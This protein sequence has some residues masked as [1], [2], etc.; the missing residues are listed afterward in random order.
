M[1]FLS[2]NY[3]KEGSNKAVLLFLFSTNLTGGLFGQP[4]IKLDKYRHP[5]V[6]DSLAQVYSKLI[7]IEDL[8]RNLSVLA[9]DAYE[10]RETG[11][12]G[13]KMAAA[14]IAQEFKKSGIP[15]Y[16]DTSY[17][18][19]FLLNVILPKPAEVYV[20]LKRFKNKK[21]FYTY[22]EQAEQH[23]ETGNIEFL[24]YGIEDKN[25]TDFK[26]ADVK[27]K[28]VMILA[29]EPYSRDSI[30]LV[31]GKKERSLWTA[32]HRLKL[33]NAKDKGIKA[34]L[35]VSDDIEKDFKN[36]KHRLE[37]PS[38]KLDLEG[39]EPFIIYISK[40]MANYILK[41]NSQKTIDELK[42]QISESRSSVNISIKKSFIVNV[43]NKLQKVS[44]ENVLAYVEGSDLKDELV[45]I[46]AHYD[47]LGV[48]GKAVF[49]GADDDGSG[50]VAVIEMAKAF[51]AA[52]KNGVGPRRSVLFMTVAG[53]EKGL[54][55]SSYYVN[56]PVYPL[57]NTVCD[58]NIDMIGRVDRLHEN[59]ANYVYLIGSDKL[60]STLHKISENANKAHTRLELDYTYNDE[61][62]KN[63]YYYRSDHYN[64]A[65][66]GIPVI[67]YF[68]GTHADYH[69]ETDEVDK[70]NFDKVKKITDLVFYT[71]W[72]LVNRDERIS[73]DSNKR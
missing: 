64:F 36:N 52:K 27:G 70:I 42:E 5:E 72:E 58:L 23:L 4:V 59:N 49:N 18:Q 14:Y 31:S 12:K 60:S 38:V 71:A 65:K 35:I 33:E 11:K 57:A 54:L 13:Q 28:V 9:S 15:A 46:T 51:E 61:K 24:G 53:E 48:E 39:D 66:K 17:F 55:G 40:K 6:N 29:G 19:E 32:Y 3:L 16:K 56:N 63:R 68:N 1:K 21:D 50:T 47:H 62:D 43:K 69:K 34:L 45:V 41:N 37:T 25:Y 73:V 7:T 8:R 26:T 20:N 44:S 30:S 22:P 2:I 10:G 67:F